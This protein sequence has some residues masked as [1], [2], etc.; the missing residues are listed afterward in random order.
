MVA[1][2][3]AHC[4]HNT[5]PVSR[6]DVLISMVEEDIVGTEASGY[7]LIALLVNVVRSLPCFVV[8]FTSFVISEPLVWPVG[9]PQELAQR[10]SQAKGR[11][12]KNPPRPHP[13]LPVRLCGLFDGKDTRAHASRLVEGARS[14]RD[15]VRQCNVIDAVDLFE[16]LSAIKT[17]HFGFVVDTEAGNIFHNSFIPLTQRGD[18]VIEVEPDAVPIA[19]LPQVAEPTVSGQKAILTK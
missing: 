14:H 9:F 13:Q 3:A 15:A 5:G 6:G 19:Q 1:H 17:D 10:A 8:D 11:G 7:P 4:S 12:G 18:V 2:V 16:F